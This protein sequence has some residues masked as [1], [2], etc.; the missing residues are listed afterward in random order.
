MQGSRRLGGRFVQRRI[1]IFDWFVERKR[2][3]VGKCQARRE[4]HP[5]LVVFR[6]SPEVS[7]HRSD[8]K[9]ASRTKRV[10]AYS[11]RARRACTPALGCTGALS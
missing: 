8:P 4:H 11:A 3:V 6:V 9:R 1:C 2:C 5:R 7:L 10:A